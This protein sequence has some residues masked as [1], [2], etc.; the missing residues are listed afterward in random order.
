[1]TTDLTRSSQLDHL[2]ALGHRRIAHLAGP[3]RPKANSD[4]GSHE[5]DD[6]ALRRLLAF[7][8][9]LKLEDCFD[10]SLIGYADSWQD[11]EGKA[12][13]VVA[14][15]LSEPNPPTAILCANDVIAAAAIAAATSLGVAV[16]A[17]LSI[18]GIDDSEL[19][20]TGPLPI[21][22]VAVPVEEI[23]RESVHCLLRLM[24]GEPVE[25]CRVAVPVTKI[26]VR[27]STAPCGP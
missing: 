15:W 27:G 20:R 13:A 21:T 3:A 10:S 7:T 4:T 16:P 9:R 12:G 1:M 22:S 18:V 23:G 14:Q 8:E 5:T 11:S 26:V 25:A 17:Q 2:F 19:A 24:G 6:N